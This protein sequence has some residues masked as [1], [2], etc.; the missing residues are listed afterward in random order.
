MMSIKAT[1]VAED[2]EIKWDDLEVFSAYATMS[3]S[4]KI[5]PVKEHDQFYILTLSIDPDKAE[6]AIAQLTKSFM[7]K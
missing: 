7:E 6:A 5:E 1:F 2:R 4:L 3:S